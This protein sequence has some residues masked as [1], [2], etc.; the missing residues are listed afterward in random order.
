MDLERSIWGVS[1][2]RP[3]VLLAG[4]AV[5]AGLA[6]PQRAEADP[7]VWWITAVAAASVGAGVIYDPPQADKDRQYLRAGVGAF[8]LID[9]DDQAVEGRLD[10]MP[11]WQ[12]YRF[13]PL[14]GAA[15]TGDG[16]AILHASIA[17]DLVLPYEHF[18]VWFEIGP[19]LYI[20]GDGKDL[21]SN[22]VLRSGFEIGFRTEGGWRIGGSFHHMS[23]GG[24]LGDDNPG[25]EMVALNVWV[26]F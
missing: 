17:H 24:L 25:T 10:Y 22:G 21:G 9:D 11:A 6:P 3:V 5:L 4:L 19:A 8:D 16:S 23:H 20:E 18:Y 12:F 15:A 14:I 1:V 26:P 7:A 13:R 2:L